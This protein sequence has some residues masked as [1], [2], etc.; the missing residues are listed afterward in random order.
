VL[1]FLL[2][3]NNYDIKFKKLE[4]EISKDL[5]LSIP[6]IRFISNLIFTK[7]NLILP[8]ELLASDKLDQTNKDH[9][10]Y[11]VKFNK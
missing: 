4:T 10:E 11:F 1:S 8:Q 3:L 9:T 6:N 7:F 2:S 5:K